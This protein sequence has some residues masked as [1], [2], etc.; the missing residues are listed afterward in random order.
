MVNKKTCMDCG[1]EFI[2]YDR[3]EKKVVCE[4]CLSLLKRRFWSSIKMGN[5]Y[6]NS[7]RRK[8]Q[9]DEENKNS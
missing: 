2:P 7:I 1:K 5:I 6:D 3:G 4:D 8:I 9:N